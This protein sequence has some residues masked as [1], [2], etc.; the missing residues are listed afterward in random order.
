MHRIFRNFFTEEELADIENTFI[1]TTRQ[2]EPASSISAGAGKSDYDDFRKAAALAVSPHAF[3]DYHDKVERAMQSVK[4][5][6]PGY[7]FAEAWTLNDYKGRDRGHFYWHKDRLDFFILET[8]DLKRY[9]PEQIFLRNTR[10]QR[11]M[12]VSVALNDRSGYT[13]GQFMIDTGDGQ[14]TPVDLNRGDLIAFDS[15]TFHSVEDVTDGTRRSLII[16]AVYSDV[17]K[18]WEEEWQLVHSEQAT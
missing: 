7:G 9:N 10:P 14:K 16:W 2:W 11:E 15:D 5:Y 3:I 6:D 18:E 13:G 8:S 4:P 12:S 1:S 17:Q